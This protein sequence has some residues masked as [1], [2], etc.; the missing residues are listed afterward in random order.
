MGTIPKKATM[1]VKGQYN[2]YQDGVN[3]GAG[4]ILNAQELG[5]GQRKSAANIPYQDAVVVNPAQIQN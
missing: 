4:Q 2:V 1:D 3:S 5:R